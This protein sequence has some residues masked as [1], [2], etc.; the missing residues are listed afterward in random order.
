M[1]IDLKGKVRKGKQLLTFTG[2]TTGT[3]FTVPIDIRKAKAELKA[4]TKPGRIVKGK[5]RTR[6]KIK[7]SALG[8]RPVTGKIVVNASGKKY[9]VK[10]KKGKA[11][12]RLAKFTKV[13]KKRIVVKYAGSGKV[14][15]KQAV[16]KIKVK[17][18]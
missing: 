15:T 3:T 10:L 11:F 5:T 17:R 16:V 4:R 6:V 18:R 12:V 13:G 14:R 2:G 7:A 1:W 8:I 9:T